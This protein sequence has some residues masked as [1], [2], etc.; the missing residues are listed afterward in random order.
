[1]GNNRKNYKDEEIFNPA[2]STYKNQNNR[3]TNKGKKRKKK[4]NRSSKKSR[5]VGLVLC[6]ILAIVSVVFSWSLYTLNM[7]PAN[8]TLII[9][10][11]LSLT[12]AGLFIQQKLSRG[13]GIEGKMLCIALTISLGMGSYY[14]IQTNN[15]F[16]NIS[17]NGGLKLDH[18][19]VVV[20][21][22]DPAME[23][24]D[25]K[26]YSF[27]VQYAL[28]GDHVTEAI[29]DVE[30]VLGKSIQLTELENINDQAEALLNGSVGALIYN[31]A[32]QGIIEDEDPEYASKIKVIYTFDIESVMEEETIDIDVAK[33][34]FA[35]YISGID[36]YG[37]ISKNSRSDV[38]ILVYVNPTS[39]QILLVNT[40]RDYYL[41]FPGVT[42]NSKDKLTH[43]GIYG[44]DVSMRTLEA[45]YDV[46][47]EYYAR[48][49][50]TSLVTMV[51]ALGG[52]SVYS[53]QSF[54]TT[55][56]PFYV[57]K[58]MNNFTGAQA[59]AFSRERYNVSGG[60]NQR[61]KNQQAVITAMI[62]K[63]VSPAILTGASKIIS[64]V[65][66][67][68]DTNMP[69][70]DIQALIKSQ[71]SDGSSW[72]ILS[73]AATGTGDSKYCYSYSGKALYVMQPNISSVN[74]IKTAIQALMNGE[75]LTSDTV[76][77]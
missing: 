22:D 16:A 25:A 18:M 10:G 50:F 9:I 74:Q 67:N 69:Q 41:S 31:E 27:G 56:D 45:L 65:S 1:M 77:Q 34:P 47:V 21:E 7:L 23:L 43:A 60:D 37:S 36:V 3:G 14:L 48:V 29:T 13:R 28:Q 40:P 35:V 63:I 51:D 70:S 53:E 17:K 68:V 19:I 20:R 24:E 49:N 44:V 61:G 73:M 57:S 71:L 38:N 52:V 26:D 39:R 59:L 30:A 32:Y 2:K 62:Q 42:G 75:V 66:G 46:D 15:M 58:G 76:A 8:Y 11:V 55:H 12:V 72:N 33:D 4:K 64:S 5:M 54:T 6:I